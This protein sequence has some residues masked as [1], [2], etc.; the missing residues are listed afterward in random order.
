MRYVFLG[1]YLVL[2]ALVVWGAVA[3]GG[4]SNHGGAWIAALVGLVIGQPWLIPLAKLIHPQ[5]DLTLLALT[6]SCA[7]NGV[8]FTV[9]LV[10]RA[11]AA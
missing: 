2:S 8:L 5:G 1:I 6:L 7:I 11:R 4:N 10:Y 3:S 9:Y